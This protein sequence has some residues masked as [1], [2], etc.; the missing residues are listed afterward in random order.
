MKI[1]YIT[2]Q[3]P[4]PP[5]SGG[6]IK[7][8]STIRALIN[9]GY[10]VI[11]FSFIENENERKYISDLKRLGIS[12]IITV[13]NKEISE[14][15][16][17]KQLLRII[18]SFFTHKPY[19]VLRYSNKELSLEISKFLKNNEID[20]FWVNFLYM[21]QYLPI[22]FKGLKVLESH[23]VESELYKSGF[24]KG[25]YIHLRL[26]HLYEWTKYSIYEKIIYKKFKI[27][28]CM[29]NRDKN[30]LEK[31]TG[32]NDIIVLPPDIKLKKTNQIEKKQNTLLFTGAL[33]WYPNRDGITWFIKKVFP[34]II[35]K[36]PTIKLWV[37]GK[38]SPN[39]KPIRLDGIEYLGFIEE[40][41]PYMEKA[42]VL[43]APIRY[44]TGLRIKIIEAMSYGLPVVTT[45]EGANGLDVTDG[46]ELFIAK[47]EKEFADKT[48]E[49]LR[50][51]YLQ[52]KLVKNAYNFL[53]ENYSCKNLIESLSVLKNFQK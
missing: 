16:R 19:G 14:K 3:L 21:A 40:I 47:N 52:E 15:S 23:D 29:S 10:S 43:I 37:I 24:K 1:L 25:M 26:L 36:I 4:Y 27:I 49:L 11:L 5:I 31:I 46:Q 20:I 51:R 38:Y 48:I 32:R 44:G 30:L 6:R 9:L 13:H 8:L 17:L 34:L 35:K 45:A 50:N 28:F 33:F 42:M 18:K 7:T 22:N 41:K 39:F 53:S 2:P 12:K